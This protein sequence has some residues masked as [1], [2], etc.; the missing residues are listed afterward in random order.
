MFKIIIK[1]KRLSSSCMFSYRD[2]FS[3]PLCDGFICGPSQMNNCRLLDSAL[4][5]ALGADT[6][7]V[8][9][10]IFTRYCSLGINALL[11]VNRRAIMMMRS[12][13]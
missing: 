9:D 1:A 12:S 7:I 4:K 3:R 2:R 10:L 11:R 8:Y 5:Q 6:G 13:L